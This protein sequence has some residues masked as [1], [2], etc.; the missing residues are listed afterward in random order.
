MTPIDNLNKFNENCELLFN[1]ILYIIYMCVCVRI[2]SYY[3]S[4][5]IE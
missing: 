3:Y 1:S 4:I 5:I 2:I